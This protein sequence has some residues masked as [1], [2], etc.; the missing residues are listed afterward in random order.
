MLECVRDVGHVGSPTCLAIDDD[1]FARV[2]LVRLRGN[3]TG[4][5]GQASDGNAKAFDGSLLRSIVSLRR[6]AA[7]A[8]QTTDDEN[9]LS[10]NDE[11]R[12]FLPMPFVVG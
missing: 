2:E 7:L 9:S 12:S 1:R 11:H 10:E 5:H 3:C 6:A 8:V 4:E